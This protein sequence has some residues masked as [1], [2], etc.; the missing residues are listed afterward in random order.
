M[1]EGELEAFEEHIYLF[2]QLVGASY[3]RISIDAIV[4][5]SWHKAM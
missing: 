3:A 2:K 4:G 5:K 1:D